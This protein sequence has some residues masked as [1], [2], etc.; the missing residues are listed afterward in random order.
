MERTFNVLVVLSNASFIS[1]QFSAAP[2]PEAKAKFEA[3]VD[4]WHCDS[5]YTRK[6]HIVRVFLSS[7]DDHAEEF[8]FRSG[9][10]VSMR[11]E[12]A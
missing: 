7:S 6:S 5:F 9:E 3:M 8:G 12:A 2:G 4:G 1:A 11:A 10:L